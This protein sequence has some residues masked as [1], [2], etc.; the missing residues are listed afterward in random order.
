M[1]FLKCSHEHI[2]YAKVVDGGKLL[3]LCLYVYDLIYIGSDVVIVNDLNYLWSK[4]FKFGFNAL[5]PWNKR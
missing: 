5:F 1:K 4:N 2:L 3:V